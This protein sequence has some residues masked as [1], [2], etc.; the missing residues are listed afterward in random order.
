M[1]V[2]LPAPFSP[3][4]AWI[5]LPGIERSTPLFAVTAP[6]RLVI[7]RISMMFII[8][9]GG[10]G[11]GA[12]GRRGDER[13]RDKW[14]QERKA[15]IFLSPYLLASSSLCLLVTPSPSRPVG[16]TT[17]FSIS[18]SRLKSPFLWGVNHQNE[19]SE[20]LVITVT[21]FIGLLLLQIATTMREFNPNPCLFRFTF[22]IAQLA[23][24]MR[25]IPPLAPSFSD[26]G[27]NRARGATHLVNH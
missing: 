22:R 19:L 17:K 8:A 24:K 21:K 2:D 11:D 27:A 1:I 12:T 26:I 10:L 16:H 5:V 3:T 18:V 9:T 14:R 7:P 4:M 23:D 25:W 20:D 13:R 6:K 15:R